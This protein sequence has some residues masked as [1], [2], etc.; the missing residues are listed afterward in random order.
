MIETSIPKLVLRPSEQSDA[1]AIWTILNEPGVGSQITPFWP[2][3]TSSSWMRMLGFDDSTSRAWTIWLGDKI[4]GLYVLGEINWRMHS[5]RV[6]AHGRS[7]EYADAGM[8]AA[9]ILAMRDWAWR[10]GLIRLWFTTIVPRDIT[11]KRVAPL[12]G[13]YEGTDRRALWID[14][15]PLDIHRFAYLAGE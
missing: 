13:R 11:E 14:G 12:G 2:E 4:I 6:L 3:A 1:A 10:N 15:K 7:R 8:G 9:V 5:A